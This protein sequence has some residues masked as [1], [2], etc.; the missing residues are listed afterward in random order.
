MKKTNVFRN[1]T[2]FTIVFFVCV[3]LNANAQIRGAV[4]NATGDAAYN[5]KELV[6]K[7]IKE[8]KVE[9]IDCAM[10]KITTKDGVHEIK[11]TG[12]AKYFP[13]KLRKKP[14]KDNSVFT[15]F[16]AYL[17]DANGMKLTD[18]IPIYEYGENNQPESVEYK[19]PF[20]FIMETP[21]GGYFT[22]ETW[23]KADYCV[24]RGWNTAKKVSSKDSK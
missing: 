4:R 23:G 1:L 11:I 16:K 8:G 17:Y 18:G 15:G 21:A 3:S 12:T 2:L 24:V 14:L 13:A 20:P 9:I 22:E 5:A 6:K 10:E 19:K 7:A